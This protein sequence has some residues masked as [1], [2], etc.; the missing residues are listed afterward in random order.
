MSQEIIKRINGSQKRT[1]G[2][3]TVNNN[4]KKKKRRL[5]HEETEEDRNFIH[6][7]IA[8]DQ[9]MNS[10]FETDDLIETDVEDQ[11]NLYQINKGDFLKEMA[12]VDVGFIH[13]DITKGNLYFRNGHVYSTENLVV[14]DRI[15]VFGTI[16]KNKGLKNLMKLTPSFG[17]LKKPNS[18]CH[19]LKSDHGCTNCSNSMTQVF[20]KGRSF[21][22][23]SVILKNII[24]GDPIILCNEFLGENLRLCTINKENCQLIINPEKQKTLN[25]YCKKITST[26]FDEVNSSLISDFLEDKIRGNEVFNILKMLMKMKNTCYMY[27]VCIYLIIFNSDKYL[28]CH[29]IL[30]SKHQL[31]C[32]INHKQYLKGDKQK[33]INCPAV[34]DKIL[35]LF[36]SADEQKQKKLKNISR[37]WRIGEG[38]VILKDLLEETEYRWWSGTSDANLVIIRNILNEVKKLHQD[39]KEE[40][41]SKVFFSFNF[42][43][44]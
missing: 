28:I 4:I 12:D 27:I 9:V 15:K 7:E 25:I 18:L 38:L 21:V 17:I 14:N 10:F 3:S 39:E 1:G 43:N 5:I 37:L 6:D 29:L 36:N 32:Q 31:C 30:G 20:S 24:A 41:I 16:V 19:A 42:F 44:F 2:L 33:I 26:S 40:W 23:R 13:E 11:Y 35:D 22:I 34:K 8:S